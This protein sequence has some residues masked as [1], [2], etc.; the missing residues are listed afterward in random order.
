ME[1]DWAV[2]K[3]AVKHRYVIRQNDHAFWEERFT[4]YDTMLRRGVFRSSSFTVTIK[5]AQRRNGFK[6]IDGDNRT[7]TKQIQETKHENRK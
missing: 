3:H 1:I 6:P 4:L 7:Y 2:A 5:E